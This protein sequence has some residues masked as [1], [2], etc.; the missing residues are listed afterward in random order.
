MYASGSGRRERKI[1]VLLRFRFPILTWG[2]GGE[3]GREGTGGSLLS[4]AV[5]LVCM[6]AGREGKRMEFTFW[7]L[8]SFSFLLAGCGGWSFYSLSTLGDGGFGRHARESMPGTL[9]AQRR[10]LR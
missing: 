3:R 4:L 2:G 1:F 7:L 9:Y 10:R 8:Q 5:I 6:P